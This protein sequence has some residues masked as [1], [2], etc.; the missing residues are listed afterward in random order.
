MKRYKSIFKE[1]FE[2]TIVED[3]NV[4]EDINK[5]FQYWGN[6]KN[7]KAYEVF[8][9]QVLKFKSG[10][11]NI[12]QTIEKWGTKGNAN[13]VNKDNFI[14][15]ISIILDREDRLFRDKHHKD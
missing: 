13:Q 1:K 12:L 4:G 5:I 6:I 15:E 7:D 8:T 9:K 3:I 2:S 10:S 14:K 11:N